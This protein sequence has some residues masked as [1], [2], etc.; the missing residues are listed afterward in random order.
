MKKINYTEIKS[1]EGI[2]KQ[3]NRLKRRITKQ[4]S[5]ILGEW[6]KIKEPFNRFLPVI[7]TITS[8]LAFAP[9][10]IDILSIG[11][12]IISSFKE[13]KKNK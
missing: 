11:G 9:L 10:V 1:L 3:K 5:A 6:D 4:E 13:K 2:Q 12:N 7:Q 8:Y